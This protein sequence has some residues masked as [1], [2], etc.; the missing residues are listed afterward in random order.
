M[1][2][3]LAFSGLVSGNFSAGE[4][5]RVPREPIVI[6]DQSRTYSTMSGLL[7]SWRFVLI[8]RSST[9]SR[10]IGIKGDG[11]CWKWGAYYLL[12]DNYDFSRRSIRKEV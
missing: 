10:T 3:L 12:P 11:S 9:R 2:R 5:L 8:R 4:I 7:P 1:I 6:S